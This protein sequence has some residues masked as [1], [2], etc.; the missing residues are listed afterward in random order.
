M[1]RNSWQPHPQ[2]RDAGTVLCSQPAFLRNVTPADHTTHG[3]RAP[4][5]AGRGHPDGATHPLPLLRA[6]ARQ[7]L[8]ELDAAV[9]AAE[10][11]AL[12]TA[13]WQAIH[14]GFIPRSPARNSP[15]CAELETAPRL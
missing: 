13:R 15:C 4:R 12:A 9:A 11:A 5:G 3:G 7:L 1:T 14:R 10:R 6:A 8:D 2:A